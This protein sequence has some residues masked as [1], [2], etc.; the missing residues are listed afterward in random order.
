MLSVSETKGEEESMM[1][2]TYR[3]EAEMYHPGNGNAQNRK[4]SFG[5]GRLKC[6]SAAFAEDNSFEDPGKLSNANKSRGVHKISTPWLVAAKG[7][8]DTREVD[9]KKNRIEV[10]SS[11]QDGRNRT[12][13]TA[14]Q[15]QVSNH[16]RSVLGLHKQRAS[17]ERTIDVPLS[18]PDFASQ[19]PHHVFHGI[20]SND[21]AT[22]TSQRVSEEENDDM[23]P[24]HVFDGITSDD[25]SSFTRQR[26][27]EGEIDDT[28]RTYKETMQ[29]RDPVVECDKNMNCDKS[30]LSVSSE[31]ESSLFDDIDT[32]HYDADIREGETSTT[33]M[34]PPILVGNGTGS[35]VIGASRSMPPIDEQVQER[36]LEHHQIKDRYLEHQHPEFP[37]GVKK[38]SM[39]FAETNITTPRRRNTR[40]PSPSKLRGHSQSKMS[41]EQQKRRFESQRHDREVLM[42]LAMQRDLERMSLSCGSTGNKGHGSS[43]SGSKKKP[44]R[45]NNEGFSILPSAMSCFN[46]SSQLDPF[47]TAENSFHGINVRDESNRVWVENSKPGSARSKPVR[48]SVCSGVSSALLCDINDDDELWE[49]YDDRKPMYRSS[50]SKEQSEKYN[51]RESRDTGNSFIEQRQEKDAMG[52]GQRASFGGDSFGEVG[53]PMPSSFTKN[54]HSNS[55]MLRYQNARHPT[56]P[57]F[58][59]EYESLMNYPTRPR[60]DDEEPQL[61][62]EE[63]LNQLRQAVQKASVQLDSVKKVKVVDSSSEQH[64]RAMTME[65]ECSDESSYV[66]NIP[67]QNRV[68]LFAEKR[69]PSEYLNNNYVISPGMQGAERYVFN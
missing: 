8:R 31:S 6:G 24:H 33:A 44:L 19:P 66:S 64:R 55:D 34:S 14:T 60:H 43:H 15:K 12:D 49:Y 39:H 22:Y 10:V 63:M 45:R 20:T 46:P 40:S 36:Y 53:H 16:L 21:F 61:T 57:Q 51:P 48:N 37:E 9:K 65:T 35:S 68:Q 67:Q 69:V 50:I 5:L 28:N 59:P 7:S 2:S 4:E 52:R 62:K 17:T 41:V 42:G 11:I 25:F 30:I 47:E 54:S 26:I 23:P 58:D 27:A 38:H 32:N 29:P 1:A 56:Q 3:P 13:D 18:K